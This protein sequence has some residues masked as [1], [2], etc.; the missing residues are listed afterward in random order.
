MKNPFHTSYND[1]DD[2]ELITSAKD[3]S[4]SSLETLVKKHQHYIYN[5]ALK[6]TLSPFDAEDITQEVLIKVITNLANFKGESNFRTWLYRIT[7]NHFLKMKKYWLEDYIT[8]FSKYGKELDQM[9]DIELSIIEKSEMKEF[10]EDAKIG[11]MS[12]MLLCLDR[13]QRLVYIL[14]EIFGIDHTIGSEMLDIS[15]D[16]FRQ[17]LSRARKDLYQFMNNKCGLINKSNPC[18][19]DKK[20]KAFIQAGWV[21]KENLKFNTSYLKRISEVAPDKSNDLNDLTEIKY[22]DL[23]KTQPFQEKDHNKNLFDNLINDNKVREIFN[24]Y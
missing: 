1:R 8:S 24:L 18:R 7:F 11:C 10:I 13:E 12:G 14:G 3:G 21:D 4:K 20:T 2:I 23:F 15:K 22:A 16:N 17:R 5:V 6:M 9:Q 19:C